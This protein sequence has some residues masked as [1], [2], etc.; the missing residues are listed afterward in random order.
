MKRKKC[1]FLR[2]K[3]L[4]WNSNGEELRRC[5]REQVSEDV[6][7]NKS[8]SVTNEMPTCTAQVWDILEAAEE[9]RITEGIE[10]ARWFARGANPSGRGS[11][12]IWGV[13]GGMMN[14]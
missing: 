3:D 8:M 1:G 2:G 4:G 6:Q 10:I 11:D 9:G 7:G 14:G 13:L 5:Q 12:C